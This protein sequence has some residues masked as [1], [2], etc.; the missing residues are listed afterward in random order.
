MMIF[1]CALS[2]L[3]HSVLNCFNCILLYYDDNIR[4]RLRFSYSSEA[5]WYEALTTGTE[6]E[7]G[8][9]PRHSAVVFF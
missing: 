4:R 8:G 3:L 7:G 1:L 2:N 5:L 9:V 6:E